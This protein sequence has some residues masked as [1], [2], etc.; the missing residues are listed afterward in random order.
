M[1]NKGIQA[2][3]K[4]SKTSPDAV[5]QR[6]HSREDLLEFQLLVFRSKIWM[7]MDT[8]ETSLTPFV[9]MQ[10][11]VCKCLCFVCVYCLYSLVFVFL[12]LIFHNVSLTISYYF[13]DSVHV[14]NYLFISKK[15][16]ICY[17]NRSWSCCRK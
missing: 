7:R 5:A 6:I 3:V 9:S 16:I 1:Q 10:L 13:D 2:N 14:K 15:I 11:N 17:V 8:T 4:S 12:F